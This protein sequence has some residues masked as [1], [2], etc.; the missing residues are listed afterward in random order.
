MQSQEQSEFIY[1]IF[2]SEGCQSHEQ[3]FNKLNPQDLNVIHACA[4]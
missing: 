1:S 3:L 2:A 4:I